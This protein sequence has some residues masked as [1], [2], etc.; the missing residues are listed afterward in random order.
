MPNREHYGNAETLNIQHRTPNTERPMFRSAD[1]SPLKRP[2]TRASDKGVAHLAITPLSG[3]KF[4]LRSLRHSMFDVQRFIRS[5]P[6]DIAPNVT[7]GHGPVEHPTAERDVIFRAVRMAGESS[8]DA[9]R[10]AAAGGPSL[11][12]LLPERSP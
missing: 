8:F 7:W 5:I 6:P 11:I 12:A 9:D 3:L 10:S 1:F 2:P 4:A